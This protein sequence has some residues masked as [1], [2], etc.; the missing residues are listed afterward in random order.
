MDL[1]CFFC[2]MALSKNE[3]SKVILSSFVLYRSVPSLFMA[4]SIQ[5]LSSCHDIGEIS[6]VTEDEDAFENAS[7]SCI[8]LN[9]E[10]SLPCQ[11]PTTQTDIWLQPCV[12]KVELYLLGILPIQLGCLKHTRKDIFGLFHVPNSSNV[13]KSLWKCQEASSCGDHNF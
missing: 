4:Q 2:L 9:I 11:L 13:F 10:G 1:P 8:P 12:K 3:V 7:I 5:C 6:K